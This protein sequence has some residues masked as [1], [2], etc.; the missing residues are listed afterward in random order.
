VYGW[1]GGK[2]VCVNLT[3]VSPLVGLGV[4]DFTVGRAAVK[5]VSSKMVKHEKMYSD[6]QHVF[7]PFAFDIFSF[8]TP[9]AVNLLKI[10]QNVMH[11][12]VMSYESMNVVF[13]N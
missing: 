6:N 9:E 1:V 11:I 3:V 5:F 10:V 2:H 7:I 13:K 4:R 8:L 12:N